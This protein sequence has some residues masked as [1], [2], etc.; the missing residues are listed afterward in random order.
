MNKQEAIE[1]IEELKK[2]SCGALGYDWISLGI[3]KALN[4]VKQLDEPEKPVLTEEEAE[5]LE[6]FKRLKWFHKYDMIHYIVTQN[7][8]NWL[9][10]TSDT[11]SKLEALSNEK[12]CD[13]KMRLIQAALCGYIIKE[14]KLYTA[15]LKST[16]EYLRFRREFK[17]IHHFKATDNDANNYEAY[18]FTK[19]ELIK[20]HAWENEAYDVKEVKE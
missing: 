2:L 19:D 5:W 3:D 1:K 10:L 16:G 4:A 13:L 18:H 7:T 14:D 6:G 8:Y 11:K 9:L 17:E 20:Y 12:L 15:K